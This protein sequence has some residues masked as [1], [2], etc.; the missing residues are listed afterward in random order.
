MSYETFYVT[1]LGTQFE[2]G[3]AKKTRDVL[4]KCPDT[5]NGHSFVF[6][7]FVRGYGR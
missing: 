6:S 7:D 2:R 3:S 1:K 4:M 5:H